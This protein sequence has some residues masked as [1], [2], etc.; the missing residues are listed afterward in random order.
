V[1][2]RT[3][4]VAAMTTTAEVAVAQTLEIL[5]CGTDMEILII[6]LPA[7]QTHGTFSMQGLQLKL[8][9][10]VVKGDILFLLKIKMQ[11]QLAPTMH[12][13]AVI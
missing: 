7:G 3:V 2:V 4:E 11:L 9:R 13:G 1:Q 10:V 12:N 5:L 8:L 6:L